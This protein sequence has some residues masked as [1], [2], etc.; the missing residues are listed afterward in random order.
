MEGSGEIFE[1]TNCFRKTWLAGRL[2][3]L[4]G[5][6]GSTYHVILYSPETNL[7]GLI[8]LAR[9]TATMAILGAVFGATSSI[10]AEL[11]DAP[12]DPKNYFIGG[13]ASGIMIG[14]KTKNFL[15]GSASCVGLG[16]LGA[17]VK[18]GKRE[19]W[20]FLVHTEK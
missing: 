19:G 9:S 10:S 20:E 8:R 11:R 3:A 15:I 16:A 5:L 13:C 14:A 2:G 18:V 4:A 7:E 12:D 17:V 1:E 6:F